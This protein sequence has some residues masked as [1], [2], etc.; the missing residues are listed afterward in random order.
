MARIFFPQYK[1]GKEGI[2]IF[3]GTILEH[4][5]KLGVEIASE[6]GGIGKC[7]RCIIRIERGTQCL[8]QKTELEKK[9]PLGEGE[10]LACQARI[11][12][13][14][15]D[16]HVFIKTFGKYSILSESVQTRVELEPFVYRK[17]NRVLHRSGED[18]GK[19]AGEILGLAV[20][21]GTTTLVMQVVD[22]ED[23]R[24]IGTLS[25]TNPQI[26]YGN[27][28]ISRIGHTMAHRGGLEELRG[29][30]VEAVNSSL[31]EMEKEK[32]ELRRFIYDAVAVGNSTMRN[33]FFNQDV[34]SLGVIPYESSNRKSISRKARDVGLSINPVG[35]VYGP[36]LIGGHA[37]ADALAD[38][39]ASGMHRDNGVVMVIDIGTN[40]EVAVGNKD[41]IMTAS[42]AAGGAYEGTTIKCGVGAI[43]G[44]I[45]NIWV[46]EGR[47]DYETIGGK[48]AVG[49]CGSGLIDL[50][51]ELLRS[52]IMSKKAKIEREFFINENISITQQDI[53]QLI[54]AKAGLRIDQDLLIGYYGVGLEDIEKIYLAGGFGNFINTE[55]AISIGLLP[56]AG[57]KVVKIGNGALA[58]A[59]E[60]ILSRKMRMEAEEVVD[61][62]EHAKPN[63]REPDFAYMVAEKMYF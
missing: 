35:N 16:I 17:G 46:S 63:E 15:T 32:G 53:Y 12:K 52:G 33:I 28:V 6:C 22:L 21:V 39:L 25:R 38:I 55:S 40:G 26:S 50:L 9:H 45:K 19:Y 29:V 5:R 37:G 36:P 4:A 7:G 3:E 41:R 42:C 27:D 48:P 47:V 56:N 58:G 62:I 54:T 51:A 18:M 2:E 1:R 11:T 8:N 57:E 44:A 61:R 30:V 20:D 13:P 34:S 23:G 14:E 59:R 49:I 10:R 31:E 43:E 60:M 24:I